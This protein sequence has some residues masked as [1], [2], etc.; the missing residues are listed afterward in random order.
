M[1]GFKNGYNMYHIR[2]LVTNTYHGEDVFQLPNPEDGPFFMRDSAPRLSRSVRRLEKCG[3]IEKV[4]REK[5]P[6]DR[7]KWQWRTTEI[8]RE[9]CRQFQDQGA[10]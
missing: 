4:R 8:W 6:R 2:Q 1:S 9:Y 3:L 10:I 5:Y 7:W